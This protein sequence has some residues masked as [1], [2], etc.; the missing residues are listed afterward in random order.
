MK[1]LLL[2]LVLLGTLQAQDLTPNQ[3]VST[4]NYNHSASAKIK[5]KRL[6]QRMATVKKEKAQEM[7]KEKCGAKVELTKLTRH[8]NRLF[9][10]MRTDSCSIKID[11]LDGSII[12]Q[13]ML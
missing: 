5:Q 13:K 12:S 2:T 7:A 4:Y 8:G 6:L 3:I 1:H 11:A 10:A 9:Y